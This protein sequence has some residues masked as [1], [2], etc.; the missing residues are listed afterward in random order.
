MTIAI[1]PMITMTKAGAKTY[2]DKQNNWTVITKDHSL[3]AHWEHTVAITED[4]CE[5]LTVPAD[6][7]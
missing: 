1:E 4:G 5:V 3:A 7:P 2:V 6:Y